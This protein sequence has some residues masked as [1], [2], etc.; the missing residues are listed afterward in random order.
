MHSLGLL[1]NADENA[2][3]ILEKASY[4][5]EQY[6]KILA[7]VT[8]DI[9]KGNSVKPARRREVPSVGRAQAFTPIRKI[10]K[11][12]ALSYIRVPYDSQL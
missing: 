12:C 1:N 8:L 10:Y 4:H 5:I 2:L 3:S 11:V 7:G 9:G 6:Y